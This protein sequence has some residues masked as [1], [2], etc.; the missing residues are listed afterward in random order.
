LQRRAGK[1]PL[2]RSSGR[3]RRSRRPLRISAASASWL[4][5][6]VGRCSRS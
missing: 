4:E 2:S 6:R 1:S 5:T 3:T